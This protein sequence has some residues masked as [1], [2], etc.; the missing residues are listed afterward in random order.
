MAAM[1]RCAKILFTGSVVINLLLGGIVGGAIV[2]RA[3]HAPWEEIKQDL[4]PETQNLLARTFQQT[5]RNMSATIGE[6]REARQE[7]KKAFSAKSFDE[8]AYDQAVEKL[9]AAQQKLMTERLRTSKEIAAQLP[10]EE[11]VKIADK[12]SS[13][14]WGGPRHGGP[15]AYDQPPKEAP[16]EPPPAE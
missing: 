10:Q 11:R 13:K 2:E 6:M 14:P 4:K 7:M 9:M 5:S 12:F 16:P 1:T 15:M 3:R 8:A